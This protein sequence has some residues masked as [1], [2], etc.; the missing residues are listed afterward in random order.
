[1]CTVSVLLHMFDNNLPGLVALSKVCYVQLA[2][3]CCRMVGVMVPLP[4]PHQC[5]PL[6]NMHLP[7]LCWLSPAAHVEDQYQHKIVGCAVHHSPAC[8][9]LCGCPLQTGASEILE[10]L[11]MFQPAV[12]QHQLPQQLPVQVAV[13]FAGGAP[14]P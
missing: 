1:M 7:L 10:T 4:W 14:V 8:K 2:L 5:E 9:E 12:P 11:S 6:Q 13:W 3:F